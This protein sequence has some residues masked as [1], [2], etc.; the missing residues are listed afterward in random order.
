MYVFSVALIEC[1]SL[2][3]DALELTGLVSVAS[4]YSR[5]KCRGFSKHFL[6][7]V[8]GVKKPNFKLSFQN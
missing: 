3:S 5:A 6:A 1:V 2:T 8:N 4:K 7:P